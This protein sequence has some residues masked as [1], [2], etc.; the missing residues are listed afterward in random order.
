MVT[1]RQHAVHQVAAQAKF[2][3][4]PTA[5]LP[6][7]PAQGKAYFNYSPNAVLRISNSKPE[8]VPGNWTVS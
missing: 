7:H 5:Q 8:V 4:A 1:R 2:L 6:V 3:V